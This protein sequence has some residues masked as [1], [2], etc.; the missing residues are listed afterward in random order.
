MPES[1]RQKIEKAERDRR[2]IE[3]KS[4]GWTFDMIAKKGKIKGVSHAQQAKVCFDRGLLN[5]TQVAA[6]Q[7]RYLENEKYDMVER[8]LVTILTGTRSEDKD[9]NAA[10]GNLIRLFERRAKLNGIDAQVETD[11]G[12]AI[13]TV[14][15]PSGIL[16]K[17]IRADDQ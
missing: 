17:T 8:T 13:K 14:F 3:L 15:I 9:R 6:D 10:A 7:Y 16:D 4:R 2:V 5:A 1:T 12:T 11:V